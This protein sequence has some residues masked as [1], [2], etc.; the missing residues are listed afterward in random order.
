ML[1]SRDLTCEAAVE[2]L[3]DLRSDSDVSLIK[4]SHG[5]QVRDVLPV[6]LVPTDEMLNAGKSMLHKSNG[7]GAREK[8]GRIFSAMLA[9]APSAGSQEQ[10]E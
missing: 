8:C 4:P 6:P 7:R 1:S 2:A 10:G 3:R 5:E 9:A